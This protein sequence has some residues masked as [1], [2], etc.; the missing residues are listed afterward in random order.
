MKKIYIL[1]QLGWCTLVDFVFIILTN[2]SLL[3]SN[4]YLI[5]CVFAV[6]SKIS[7]TTKTQLIKLS[8]DAPITTFG[9]RR[10]YRS[11]PKVK[12]QSLLCNS[13]FEICA[14]ITTF[15]S[16]GC[17]DFICWLGRSY[18]LHKRSLCTFFL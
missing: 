18:S 13:W 7:C 6:Q 5:N 16:T 2:Y 4:I 3:K 10:L 14:T 1:H 12:D 9:D 8:S 11:S 17:N 15:G